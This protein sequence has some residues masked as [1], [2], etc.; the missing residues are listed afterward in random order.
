[1]ALAVASGGRRGLSSRSGASAPLRT[2]IASS[3][4]AATSAAGAGGTSGE[5]AP[6]LIA[7]SSVTVSNTPGSTHASRSGLTCVPP[8]GEAD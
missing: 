5:P 3:T 8:S 4:T 1:M 7:P 2:R 6:G